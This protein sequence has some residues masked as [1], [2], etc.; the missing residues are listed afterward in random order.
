MMVLMVRRFNHRSVT[1]MTARATTTS[2]KAILWTGSSV[3]CRGAAGTARTDLELRRG[4][5]TATLLKGNLRD[6]GVRRREARAAL[7]I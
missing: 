6:D 7:K 2:N 1:Q 3:Q 5:G 4:E